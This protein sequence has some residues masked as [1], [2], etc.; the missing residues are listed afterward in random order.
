MKKF[1]VRLLCCFVPFRKLRRE[2]RN[3]FLQG[4]E[5]QKYFRFNSLE[6]DTLF[7]EMPN[8]ITHFCAWGYGNAGDNI[9]VT[10][11]R[12]LL[13]KNFTG[14]V[15]VQKNLRVLMNETDVDLANKTSAVI[16][17]GGGLFLADTNP[18][19]NSGW[20]WNAPIKLL[21]KI[22]SPLFLMGVG[23]NRFR[24][25]GDFKPIFTKHIRAVAEKAAFIGLR[26][27]G[28]IRALKEYLPPRL[29]NKV[30]FHPCATTVLSKIYDIP[31]YAGEPFVALNAAFDRPEMRY[32][33]DKDNILQG[34]AMAVKKLSETHKIKYY[35]FHPSDVEMFPY[36]DVTGVEYEKVELNNPTTTLEDIMRECAA[37]ELFIGMRGHAQLIPFGCGTPILSLISHDKLKWFLEDVKHTEWGIEATDENLREKLVSH[38]Y[39]IIASK[40]EVK[41]QI[42]SAKNELYNILQ[43]NVKIIGKHIKTKDFN[44]E[45][46]EGR[47]PQCVWLE[48]RG[49]QNIGARSTCKALWSMLKNKIDMVYKFDNDIDLRNTDFIQ[50][51]QAAD[52][53]IINGEG[54]M[55]FSTPH[56]KELRVHL[57]VCKTAKKMNP[58]I[59]TFYV[60]AIAS[61][62]AD[63]TI[64]ADELARIKVQMQYVDEFSVRD[65]LS[66]DFA[67]AHLT[68]RVKYIPEALFNWAL[69]YGA[70][71]PPSP[72]DSIMPFDAESDQYGVFDFSKPYIIVSDTSGVSQHTDFFKIVAESLQRET[73]MKIYFMNTSGTLA[74]TGFQEIPSSINILQAAAILGNARAFISGRFHPS[75]MASLGGTPCIITESNSHK[76]AAFVDYFKNI[77]GVANKVYGFRGDCVGEIVSETKRV[78]NLGDCLREKIHHRAKELG[79]LSE[80]IKDVL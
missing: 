68:P 11:M 34:I 78:I 38:A 54:S 29:H 75:I 63:G 24:G 19:D 79:K 1:L 43:N 60:N 30:R 26:N 27:H 9:L 7:S 44:R 55:I 48:R 51:L 73:E 67:K 71:P 22:K 37:P 66:F 47:K 69:Q 74:I 5:P 64:N 39:E 42:E 33:K 32:G 58:K 80:K 53:L 23:Y 40:D 46:E 72:A 50:A 56:R 36:L 65:M 8:A 18:N 2:I 35:I 45:R 4:E 14:L 76:S 6:Q 61:P 17:G 70:I 59:K 77:D 20:Q 52:Y 13:T 49:R 10:S 62:T 41:S 15:F 57:D 31:Q 16:V 25:Q 12:D 21:R 3:Y 28:S